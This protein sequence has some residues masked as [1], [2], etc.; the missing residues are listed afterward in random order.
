ML[1]STSGIV[2][3]GTFSANALRILSFAYFDPRNYVLKPKFP[4][5]FIFIIGS[6]VSNVERNALF[7]FRHSG[8]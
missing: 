6:T 8:R 7:H 5:P 4:L 3:S 2:A 1:A